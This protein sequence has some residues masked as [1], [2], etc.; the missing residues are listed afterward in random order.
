MASPT[1]K[2]NP[3]KLALHSSR[4]APEM[5]PQLPQQQAEEP[6]KRPEKKPKKRSRLRSQNLA[7]GSYSCQGHSWEKSLLSTV[8]GNRKRKKNPNLLSATIMSQVSAERWYMP[9]FVLSQH[10]DTK[11]LH[12]MR[13]VL[14]AQKYSFVVVWNFRLPKEW[15]LLEKKYQ[16]IRWK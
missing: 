15:L 3:N 4:S 10:C 9:P 14:P 16:W 6:A 13:K 5:I 2:Q 1:L 11:P 8:L 12:Q 7:S